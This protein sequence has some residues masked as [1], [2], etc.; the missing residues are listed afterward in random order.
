MTKDEFNRMLEWFDWHQG[1]AAAEMGI[2]T[3]TVNGYARGEFEIPKL[4]SDWLYY[5]QI[6]ESTSGNEPEKPQ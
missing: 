2:S 5:R 3:R 6:V 4:V 1:E